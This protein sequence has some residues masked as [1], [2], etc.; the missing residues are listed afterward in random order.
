MPLI[1]IRVILFKF[2]S[3]L[4]SQLTR[5][6]ELLTT[7]EPTSCADSRQFPSILWY[8][9]VHYRIHKSSP[10]VSTPSQTNLFHTTQSYFQKIMLMLSTH[11]CLG[12]P[13]GLFP[14]SFPINNLYAVLFCP[15]RAT[16][17][18]HRILL[19]LITLIILGK[20]HG[21]FSMLCICNCVD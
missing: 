2:S 18:A 11:L 9:K 16:F 17:P 14:S 10:P 8:Q 19:D 13:S 15:I 1:R 7:R 5:S 20:G 12:L 21:S 4:L 3:S 6:M